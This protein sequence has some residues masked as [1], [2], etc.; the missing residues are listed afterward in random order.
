MKTIIVKENLTLRIDKFLVRNFFSNQPR[1]EI[2][3]SLKVGNILVNEKKIK[4]SYLVKKGD[5]IRVRLEK[6]PNQILPNK[7]ITVE[8]IFKNKDFAV[9]NK[10]AGLKVH[11]AKRGENN[12]LVNGLLAEFPESAKVGDGSAGS[13]LRP[14]IVHRLDKETS[15]VLIFARN[16]KAFEELKKSF[17]EKKVRKEYLAL[18][19]GIMKN[20]QGVI[21]KDLARSKN[22]KKQLIASAKTQRKIRKAETEYKRLKILGDFSLLAVFPKTGRTHQI[23]VHLASLGHPIAGDKIYKKKRGRGKLFRPSRQLLHAKKIEF[24]FRGKFFQFKTKLPQ[25]FSDFL[26][27]LE[28]SLPL[29]KMGPKVKIN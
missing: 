6:T 16:Q 28:P 26:Q 11:P 8:I 10:P 15:G 2:I 9:V 23:R 20:K 12:T 29:T 25:D 27:D 24:N 5:R 7:K 3:R 18:V 21:Q 19:E 14:G 22:Y 4:P 13:F 1:A 17:Q